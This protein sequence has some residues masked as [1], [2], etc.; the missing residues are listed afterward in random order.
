MDQAR[1]KAYAAMNQPTHPGYADLQEVK[2]KKDG[3]NN[4]TRDTRQEI[5]ELNYPTSRQTNF[6]K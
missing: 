3:L 2:S 6:P 4:R 1:A 5:L